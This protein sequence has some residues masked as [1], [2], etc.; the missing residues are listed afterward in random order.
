MSLEGGV[1]ALLLEIYHSGH[2]HFP[3]RDTASVY[4]LQS[5]PAYFLRLY[6]NGQKPTG[7]C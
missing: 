2:H 5:S 1:A 6:F 4:S 7:M 3:T